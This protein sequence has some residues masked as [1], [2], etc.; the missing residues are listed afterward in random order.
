MWPSLCVCC[1]AP[2]ALNALF[3][4]HH[5]LLRSPSYHHEATCRGT[6]GLNLRQTRVF[7]VTVVRFMPGADRRDGGGT[8]VSLLPCPPPG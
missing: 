8:R 4:M 1:G 3:I 5:I 6:L 2:E 7:T